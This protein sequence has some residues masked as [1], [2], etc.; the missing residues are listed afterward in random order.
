ML[1]DRHRDAVDIHLLEGIGADHRQRHL[2][3][4][5]DHRNRVEGSVGD[6]GDQ[7]GRTRATGSDAHLRHAGHACHALGHE[8]RTLLVA[9]QHMANQ[10]AARKGIVKRQDGATGNTGNG[11]HT[12]TFEEAHK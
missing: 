7:V 6:R 10:L 8:A 4:D 3:G 12:L 11:A 5:D 2:A 9:R 1:G